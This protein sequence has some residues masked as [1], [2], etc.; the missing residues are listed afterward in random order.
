[1]LGTP[2]EARV[3]LG[4]PRG[5]A[6]LG[7]GGRNPS[8]STI[9]YKKLRSNSENEPT[10]NRSAL[11]GHH[12]LAILSSLDFGDSSQSWLWR[13]LAVL[14]LAILSSLGDV[15]HPDDPDLCP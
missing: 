4:A 7:G 10:T 6:R 1:M 8:L 5:S 12:A 11:Y 15:F 2:R 9:L 3:C 13:F 14:A